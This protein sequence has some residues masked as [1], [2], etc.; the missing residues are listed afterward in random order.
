V[1]QQT[2]GHTSCH[3][4]PRYAYASR[5]KKYQQSAKMLIYFL[6]QTNWFHCVVSDSYY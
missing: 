5:G 6:N 3:D 2:D 1:S 4:I